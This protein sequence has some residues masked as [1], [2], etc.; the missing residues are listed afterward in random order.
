M[1]L[2]YLF[3]LPLLY[4][5]YYLLLRPAGL[6]TGPNPPIIG[7]SIPWL[8][9]GLQ[10]I[11]GPP[12]H[13]I[14]TLRKQHGDT[15]LLYMF[16]RYFL[17]TFS[18][19][20][21]KALYGLRESDASFAEATKGLLGLK[22][23]PEV[24]DGTMKKFHAGLKKSLLFTYANY[25]NEAVNSVLANTELIQNEGKFEIFSLMKQIVHR[26]G[27]SCWIGSECCEPQYLNQLIECFEQC[28]PEK[29]F[30]SLP[31]LAW[32]LLSNQS[33]EKAAIKRMGE[34]LKSI[35][36]NRLDR[37]KRINNS[38]LDVDNLDEIVSDAENESGGD[39]TKKWRKVACS[40]I[41]FQVAS[42]AN[43]Y[44]AASWTLINLLTQPKAKLGQLQSHLKQ[45]SNESQLLDLEYLDG[46]EHLSSVIQES[47]RLAQQ[48]I[49]L[50]KVMSP[51]VMSVD[52]NDY[53][54]PVGLTIATLLSVTNVDEKLLPVTPSVHEF[55]P[56]RYSVDKL[57]AE[58]GCNVS[59]FGHGY[60]SCPGYSFSLYA[61]K[62]IVCKL[63]VN[64]QMEP[65]FESAEIPQGSIGAIARATK[66]CKVKY[67]KL[68]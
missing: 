39:E 53:Q 28:D 31:T 37:R 14:Q 43:L 36:L 35:W 1:L 5:L 26:I 16:G 62:L 9:C 63:L 64:L 30:T 27:F 44:A 51:C 2:T 68:K 38:Q 58:Y 66:P 42:Q 22:L 61:I 40:V 29:G 59:T 60:H 48:S 6:P 4:I 11:F 52:G 54:L 47:L 15:F 18:T 67:T 34:I 20:G 45:L 21:L 57:S 17:Y 41:Q 32:T 13:Y 12:K 50:R 23:P 25:M 19:S 33:T 49:T 24:L 7:S 8:G 55:H 46:L 3:I 65:L 10:F 56:D